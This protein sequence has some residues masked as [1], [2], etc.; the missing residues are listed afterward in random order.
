MHP[1]AIPSATGLAGSGQRSDV[2]TGD[3]IPTPGG[4]QGRNIPREGQAEGSPRQPQPLLQVFARAEL[5]PGNPGKDTGITKSQPQT[6]I[7]DRLQEAAALPN[8][9]GWFGT[10][11]I[12]KVTPDRST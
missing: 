10:G 1:S 6:G 9:K 5:S 3:A 2:T 8:A 11:E 4:M 7:L 12:N